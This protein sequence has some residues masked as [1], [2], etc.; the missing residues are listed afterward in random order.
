MK[1]KIA[2][3]LYISLVTVFLFSLGNA[4]LALAPTNDISVLGDIAPIIHIGAGA[5]SILGPVLMG[6]LNGVGGSLQVRSGTANNPRPSVFSSAKSDLIQSIFTVMQSSLFTGKVFVG[7]GEGTYAGKSITTLPI[8]D[9]WTE[10]VVVDG[11]TSGSIPE[12]ISVPHQRLNVRGNILTTSLNTINGNASGENNICVNAAGTLVLC[13]E[14]NPIIDFRFDECLYTGASGQVVDQVGTV[15]NALANG[16]LQTTDFGKTGRGLNFQGVLGDYVSA[17]STSQADVNRGEQMTVAL[18]LRTTDM[19]LTNQS[20]AAWKEGGCLGWYIT[21]ETNGSLR[22]NFKSGT[23]CDTHTESQI[24]SPAD[25]AY[26]GLWHHVVLTLD[27][28][29]HLMQQYVDG[30]EVDTIS[31]PST[32]DSSGGNLLFGTHYD[33]TIAGYADGSID[34]FKIYRSILN[35]S[36]VQELYTQEITT[37]RNVDCS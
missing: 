30:V 16:T 6:D 23:D 5:Q 14:K 36:E 24:T 13:E 27:R 1:N 9:E 11:V 20:W 19:A 31:I 28:V 34:E 25:I 10:Q 3:T 22:S 4:V 12:G 7:F 35:A 2:T 21:I 32:G 29:N 33:P 17:G 26:D 8:I 37:P 18:W 15:T